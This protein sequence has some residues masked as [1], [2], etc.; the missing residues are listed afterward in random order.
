MISQCKIKIFSWLEKRALKNKLW[1]DYLIKPVLLIMAEREE[2]LLLYVHYEKTMI[3][4]LFAVGYQNYARLGLVNLRISQIRI[5]VY[6]AP[7]FQK[8]KHVIQH[9]NGL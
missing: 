1:I 7:Y 8:G 3:P 6:I 9:M 2:G 4:Y 5:S